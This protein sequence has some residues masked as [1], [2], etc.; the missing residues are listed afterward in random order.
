MSP[1]VL[2]VGSRQLGGTARCRAPLIRLVEVNRGHIAV[3]NGPGN[4]AAVDSTPARFADRPAMYALVI[5]RYTAPLEEIIAS[6]DDHRV[7]SGASGSA[8]GCSSGPFE[9]RTGGAPL[10][11]PDGTSLESIRDADPFHQRGLAEYDLRHWKPVIGTEGA[12][13][14]VEGP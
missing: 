1:S 5:L 10:P 6:T 9:P 7:T 12:R 13:S 8:A 2:L 14:I 3:T 11:A 4:D